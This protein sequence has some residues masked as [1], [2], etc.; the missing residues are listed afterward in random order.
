MINFRIE[1]IPMQILRERALA[2]NNS[3]GYSSKAQKI[4]HG[5]TLL[6]ATG[7]KTSQNATGK[8]YCR[9][10]EHD[11]TLCCFQKLNAQKARWHSKPGAAFVR[12]AMLHQNSF[13]TEEDDKIEAS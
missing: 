8:K 12:H 9:A 4:L 5:I 3:A 6:Q 10:I 13:D 1:F 2:P 7:H 11:S